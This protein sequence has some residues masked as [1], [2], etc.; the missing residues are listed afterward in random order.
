MYRT[1]NASQAWPGAPLA[2]RIAAHRPDI[3]VM[4]V[5]SPQSEVF[6]DAWA[7]ALPPCW[8]LCVGQGVK[9]AL[10]LV[11]RAPPVMQAAQAE[12]LWRL[13]QEPRRLAGRYSR[14]AVLFLLAVL[15]DLAGRFRFAAELPAAEL[16]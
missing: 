3:L 1:D 4:G 7:A 16:P 9:V 13:G 15:A 5:G 14:G 6:A 2:A 10:G 11:R 12:F 8:V